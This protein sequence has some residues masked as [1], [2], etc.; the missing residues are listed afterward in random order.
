MDEVKAQK[1]INKICKW[2]S[3]M[4]EN[5]HNDYRDMVRYDD[6]ARV[7]CVELLEAADAD[8]QGGC[9]LCQG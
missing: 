1:M 8:G 3:E 2:L 4:A 9:P 5:Q 7:Y 6:I